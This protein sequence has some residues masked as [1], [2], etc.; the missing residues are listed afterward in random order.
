[1]AS[2]GIFLVPTVI[3]AWIAVRATMRAR[4]REALA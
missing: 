1:L 4:P 2:V 3:L